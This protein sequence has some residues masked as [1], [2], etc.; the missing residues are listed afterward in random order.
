MKIVAKRA[1]CVMGI[2]FVIIICVYF[3][4][5]KG[6]ILTYDTENSVSVYQDNAAKLLERHEDILVFLEEEVYPIGKDIFISLKNGEIDVSGEAGKAQVEKV[7]K[8]KTMLKRVFEELNC[9]NLQLY[10]DEGKKVLQIYLGDIKINS[11]DVFDQLIFYCK[12][13]RPEDAGEEIFK[14]WYYGVRFYT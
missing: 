11:D 4:S 7:I 12:D 6:S 13:G 2:A 3:L 14:D 5:T 10:N 9:E 1:I 8:H